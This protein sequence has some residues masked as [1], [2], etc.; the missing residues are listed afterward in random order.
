MGQLREKTR[1]KT[2][3]LLEKGYRVVE[4]WE[5]EFRA[6][7]K[8]DP[9]LKD[10]YEAREPYFPLKAR[11]A[12]FG[13]RT[14]AIRLHCEASEGKPLR[15]VDFTSLY[16]WVCKYGVFPLGHPTVHYPETMPENVQGLMRCKVLP[17][18]R[19]FHPVL[20]AR[21]NGKLLF[22]LCGTCAET[23]AQ[24]TCTHTDEERALIGTWVT[25]ELDKALEM[26][27]QILERY[28]AWHFDT[29]TQLN[30]IT[31]DKGLWAECMDLWLKVKQE[32]SGYPSPD[33]TEEEKRRYIEDYEAHEGVK[34]DPFKIE[35]NEG[36]R[37]LGKLMINSHWGKFGQNP[38]KKKVVYVSDP[39]EYVGYMTD[40]SIE[41]MELRYANKEH[42][43]L[44]YRTKG[45][46]IEA[47]PN[48]NVVLA[49]YTT[50][51]ARL[52][53]YTLLEGLQ[54]RVLYMDTDSVIYIHDEEK[55]N[56]PLGP[57]LG[58]LK[59][60][61]CGVNIQRFVSGGAKNYAY[62][63]QDGSEVCKIRGF[64]L[65]SRNARV[66]NFKSMR[67]LVV[68]PEKR[69]QESLVLTDPYKIVRKDHLY[70]EE[71]K[72]AYKVVYDKRRLLENLTTLPYGWK[73]L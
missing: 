67:E 9:G 23:Q 58:E 5:C 66:L 19:L 34:L 6:D 35:K 15:Y 50:T 33:L 69:R 1:K 14:N 63:L 43:A 55:W 59:D 8:A 72:K 32:A 37:S 53:L 25:L 13:G 73:D 44:T 22:P 41:V 31:G 60:E 11:E 65:N 42:V 17:P 48:T 57:Y 52:K 10:F 28:S 16:P 20:P 36:K 62:Q 68:T 4:K 18:A 47:L 30:P 45:E 21:I 64:T 38:D 2:N 51:Q 49:A 70:T 61:T 29:V 26:G 46:F 27:Y 71:Q 54:E 56:P 39:E 7:I 12:F 40:S 24:G 3:M